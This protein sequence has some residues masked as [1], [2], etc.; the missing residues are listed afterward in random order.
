MNPYLILGIVLACLASAFGGVHVGKKLERT[1][2][3]EKEI[4]QQAEYQA[5]YKRLTDSAREKERQH[6]EQTAQAQKE[7]QD[8]LTKQRRLYD[9]ENARLRDG[10]IVLRVPV[11]TT[12]GSTSPEAGSDPSRSTGR[13]TAE[14]SG[15][16]AEA[17]GRFGSE[18]DEVVHQLK[19]CQSIIVKDRQ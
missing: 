3:Q 10:S 18:V 13:A 5:T 12:C 7:Y 11:T 17:I 16:I 8:A 1:D 19:L 4:R 14:L 15:E 9:A 2:W 6:V